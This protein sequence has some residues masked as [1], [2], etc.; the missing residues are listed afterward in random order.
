MSASKV[1]I[2]WTRTRWKSSCREC[3]KCSQRWW[4]TFLPARFISRV[5]S[6]P[7]SGTH[8]PHPVPAVVA[9]LIAPTEPRSSARMALQMTPL[10]TFWQVQMV[11]ASGSASTPG[12]ATAPPS[13]R[14]RMNRSGCGG[15]AALLWVS[16]R[17]W[18]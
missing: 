7:R 8:D 9:A 16:E 14:G 2:P 18:V 5:R 3:G 4:E 11:A 10:A 6:S 12:N 17:R 15:R 13:I 1:R